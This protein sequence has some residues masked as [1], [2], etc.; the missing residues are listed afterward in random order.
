MPQVTDLAMLDNMMEAVRIVD[1]YIDSGK[2][3]ARSTEETVALLSE[4]DEI[5]KRMPPGGATKEEMDA[6]AQDLIDKRKVPRT[7]YDHRVTMGAVASVIMEDGVPFIAPPGLA[8]LLALTDSGPL[9]GE[10][11]LPFQRIWLDGKFEGHK[12]TYH[13]LSAYEVP[14]E[15][16]I[17]LQAVFRSKNGVPGFVTVQDAL[18]AATILIE[19]GDRVGVRELS[20]LAGILQNW[21]YL[22]E[23]DQV[24]QHQAAVPRRIHDIHRRK[25]VKNPPKTFVEIRVKDKALQDALDSLA[26]QQGLGHYS[27][28]FR[29]RGHW[30]TYTAERYKQVRGQRVWILPFVKGSGI[31]IDKTYVH[32][33]AGELQQT[34]E[35]ERSE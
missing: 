28:A 5:I 29:V 23:S 31:L 20:F 19:E 12:R 22:L 32:A 17:T 11:H 25:G 7:D 27:H 16:T 35:R 4:L 13:G 21:L 24:E 1:A 30:R 15:G 6:I 2:G 10:Q 18:G 14:G 26:H 3:K 8:E 33:D 34:A 9:A